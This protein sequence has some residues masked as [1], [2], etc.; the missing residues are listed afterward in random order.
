MGTL[1]HL[2]EDAD[3]M[4]FRKSGDGNAYSN[5]PQDN[6]VAMVYVIFLWQRKASFYFSLSHGFLR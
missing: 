3:E 4:S 1:G 2:P 6:C 5:K